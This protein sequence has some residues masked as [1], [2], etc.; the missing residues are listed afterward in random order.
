V[1]VCV[2]ARVCVCICMCVCVRACV[3]VSLHEVKLDPKGSAWEADV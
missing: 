1:S 2:C 3:C